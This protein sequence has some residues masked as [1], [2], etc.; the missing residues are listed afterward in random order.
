MRKTLL[1]GFNGFV[2][3]HIQN[4]LEVIPFCD[5][6][7]G[8][9]D[10]R[11]KPALV[12][13]LRNNSVDTVLHIAA[14]SSVPESFKDPLSTFEVNFL[15]THNLLQALKDTGFS[16]RFLYIGSGD[17]YGTVPLEKLPIDESLLLKPRNP[18][19]VSKVAAEALCYQWSQTGPFEVILARPF[20]HIGPGQSELFSVADFA[21]QIIQ[22]KHRFKH[23]FLEVGDIDVMRDFTDVRDVVRAY[24]LL[25]EKGKNGEIY[26]V[27]SGV[28]Y[29]LRTIIQQ[30]LLYAGVDASIEISKDRLRRVEQRSVYA[31]FAK[32]HRDTGWK[33]LIPMSQ[34]LK[35]ILN[36]WETKLLCTKEH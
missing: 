2:G 17:V 5:S 32:L 26:N 33:P 3:T 14:Q 36:D 19:A 15:G 30:L 31:S 10:L 27:C 25:L 22:M 8:I 7:Q 1:T 21:S 11:D 18:Y 6:S 29:L 13:F 4:V 24:I 34:T 23:P 9:I 12:E 35:D 20:N 28:G 16:G